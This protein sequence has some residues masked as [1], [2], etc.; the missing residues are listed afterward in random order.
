VQMA[1]VV[2]TSVDPFGPVL[3]TPPTKGTAITPY[4]GGQPS[5]PASGIPS[6]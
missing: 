6:S 4:T 1:K 5:P 2:G 3:T